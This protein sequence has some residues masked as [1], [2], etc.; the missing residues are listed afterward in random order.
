V[1]KI[2]LKKS[3]KIKDVKPKLAIALVKAN[4]ALSIETIETPQKK[5]PKKRGRKPKNTYQTKD[6]VAK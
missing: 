1:V 4:L 6:M 2:L 3:S 5:E